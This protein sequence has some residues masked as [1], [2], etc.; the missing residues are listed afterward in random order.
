MGG[1]HSNDCCCS[2]QTPDAV[3][4]GVVHAM[5]AQ[6]GLVKKRWW[7]APK[8]L[9]SIS[10]VQ[11][12]ARAVGD[13]LTGISG[14]IQRTVHCIVKS[15]GGER[16]ETNRESFDRVIYDYPRSSISRRFNSTLGDSL[17]SEGRRL[18]I[19]ARLPILTIAPWTRE[20]QA[21]RSSRQQAPGIVV[22]WAARRCGRYVPASLSQ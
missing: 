6:R 20:V 10:N 1:I 22:C 14:A 12:H 13:E 3:P 17:A 9:F 11:V 18:P 16:K 21:A 4:D 15:D 8:F 5:R 7:L 19:W 2:K